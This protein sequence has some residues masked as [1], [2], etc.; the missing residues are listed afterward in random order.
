MISLYPLMDFN[1]SF[2]SYETIDGANCQTVSPKRMTQREAAEE[3]VRQIGLNQIQ[4]VDPAIFGNEDEWREMF[5]KR[6]DVLRQ[7]V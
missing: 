4:E 1:Q 7:A 6:L 3:A 5:C 2:Y